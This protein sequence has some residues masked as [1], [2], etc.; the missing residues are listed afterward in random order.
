MSPIE[1]HLDYLQRLPVDIRAE[2]I[3]ADLL[4]YGLN[5]DDLVMYSLGLSK[6]T[7]HRDIESIE[8][9]K[10]IGDRTAKLNVSLNREGIYD[11]LPEGLFHQPSNRKPN[12]SKEETLQEI[13][14]QK[15]KEKA[16]RKFF[17]PLEQEFFRQ[18]ILLETEE[19]ALLSND[20]NTA[21]DDIFVDFWQIPK[22]FDERQTVNLSY[23]L[24][25]AHKIA[26]NDEQTALCFSCILGN[27]VTLKEADPLTFSEK[28]L[29]ESRLNEVALGA[30]FV[31]GNTY[32][33]LSPATEIVIENLTKIQLLDY[34]PEGKKTM[35]MTFL[36]N[37]FIPFENDTRTTLALQETE[38]D[39]IL[40]DQATDAR[41]GYSCFLAMSDEL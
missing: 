40:T 22:V 24:P 1:Q 20:E 36:Q 5:P 17:L 18:R 12:K 10:A 9:L 34:L 4:E 31:I 38:K 7:F 33:E 37:Y 14:V 6:R 30:D 19:R 35:M 29:P 16:A 41:L 15:G 3:L 23:L 26:G 11:A 39:F 27:E 25:I 13:K 28:E 32:Q 21:Q 2:V 8:L